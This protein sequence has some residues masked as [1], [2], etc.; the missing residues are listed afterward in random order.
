MIEAQA[1]RIWIV[2]GDKAGD[3]AQV[4]AVIE[5]LPWPVEYRRLQFKKP[6]RR[7]GAANLDAQA[8]Q[9]VRIVSGSRPD[10]EN[11]A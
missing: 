7:V 11:P 9:K 8:L 6:F 4:E 10:F 2:V 1:P 3:N 5:R